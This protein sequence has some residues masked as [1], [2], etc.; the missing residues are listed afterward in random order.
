M[1]ESR[2]CLETE[3][4]TENENENENDHENE[5]ENEASGFQLPITYLANKQRIADHIVQDLELIENKETRKSLY[6]Y[7]FTPTT[8]FGKKS[9][10]LWKEYYT[11]DTSFLKDTQ[12]LINKKVL[13][14]SSKASAELQNAMEELWK[15]VK[16]DT[17]MFSEKYHYISWDW[18]KHLNSNSQ[19]LQLL[20]LYN[21]TSPV[22]SLL[23]PVFF[24]ILPFFMLR[25][26]GIPLTTTRYIEILKQMFKQHQ[27]GQLFNISNASW[28]KIIYGI[29]SFI[30]YILQIYQN[31]SS[32]I[33]FYKNMKKIHYQLAKTQEYITATLDDMNVFRTKCAKLQTYRPFIASLEK[34]MTVLEK[35]NKE[36]QAVLP[37]SYSVKKFCQI[38]YVMKCFY[39]LYKNSEY[40]EAIDYAF[41]FN[42]Y[43]DNL[44]SLHANILNK[45]INSG[46]VFEK[47]GKGKC[48]GKTS[49]KAAYFPTLLDSN[50][51]PVKNDYRLDKHLIITGPNAAGKTTLL[52][53]TLFNIIL[54]QQIGHGFYKSAKLTPYDEIH[55]YINIPDTSGRDSLFQAEARRGK[56]IL[57]RIEL[58]GPKTRHFCVFDEL[59]SGTNPY[60]AIA[61]AH[62]F[63]GHLNNQPQVHFMLT[64]HFLELC[65]RLDSVSE[66]TNCH[67]EINAGSGTG[68]ETKSPLVFNYTYKLKKGI[69]EVKGAVKV[70]SDL[71]YPSEIIQNATRIIK[72]MAI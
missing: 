21:M 58:R 11:A 19:F 16:P 25:A 33:S 53:T 62:A 70:L 39:Q 61:S 49:F 27:L 32:C 54:T 31:I 23:M 71:A 17:A 57:D 1:K 56:N 51:G 7:V 48:K 64:T 6:D 66:I 42:G 28:D 3:T 18:F 15:E 37:H 43:L 67:M 9:L 2:N 52:K 13:L 20:C 69:S 72:E 68:P 45:N 47:A 12:K 38:G 5:N 8:V 24:L 34:K 44:A 59:Y 14:Q 50:D 65:K 29:G 41:Y 60:E 40:R 46:K 10:P 63:L 35:M 22:I 55:S 26:K 4:E 36:F 30:F